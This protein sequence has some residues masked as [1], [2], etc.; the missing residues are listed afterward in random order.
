MLAFEW[1][2]QPANWT[3]YVFALDTEGVHA[4]GCYVM[5]KEPPFW[6]ERWRGNWY[7]R[8]PSRLHPLQATTIEEAKTCLEVIARMG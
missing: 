3:L 4:E 7:E 8:P 5:A 1:Q 2:E 6:Y